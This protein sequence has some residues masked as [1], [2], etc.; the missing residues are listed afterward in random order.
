MVPFLGPPNVVP[1]VP[2]L[3]QFWGPFSGPPNGTVFRSPK[4][5]HVFFVCVFTHVSGWGA[6]G[7]VSFWGP[8]SGHRNGTGF[9]VQGCCFLWFGAWRGSVFGTARRSPNWDRFG[10]PG[11]CFFV[12]RGFTKWVSFGVQH[13]WVP[14]VYEA[15]AA[16]QSLRNSSQAG[17]TQPFA[18]LPLTPVS[19][20]ARRSRF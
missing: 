20:S 16:W 4:R 5:D 18:T 1:E 8:F 2:H 13:V 15:S 10:C 17:H 3:V 9:G 11:L 14:F 12:A 7:V 6:V 19:W